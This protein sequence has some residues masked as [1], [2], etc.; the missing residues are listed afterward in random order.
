MGR[1][2]KHI[3]VCIN[4]RPEN[5]PKGCCLL[6]GSVEIR[7]TFKNELK[8]LGISSTVRANNA[9]CLDACEFGPTIV[10]Y[11][12]GVWYG[13]VKKE[14]IQEIIQE[15]IIQGKV[16]ERLLIKEPKY[17]TETTVVPLQK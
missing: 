10:I 15:H 7:D 8:K 14:D 5:D 12:E 17:R 16:V 4:E 6:K 1:F 13:G 9:G 2:Q 3:F 11:P